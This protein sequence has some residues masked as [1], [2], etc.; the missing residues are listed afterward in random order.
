[1]TARAGKG[2]SSRGRSNVDAIM[3]KIK[4]AIEERK[5]KKSS[6]IDLST[7]ENWLIRSELIDACKAAINQALTSQNF[8]YP[9]GFSGDPDLLDAL[10]NFFND[11]FRP[12]RPVLPDHLMAAPGASTCIDSLLYNICDA[13]DGVLMPGP[14]WNGF[15]FGMRVRSSVTP[16]LVPLPS[17]HS[18]FNSDELLKALQIAME[19]ATCPVKALMITNPHNPLALCYAR[20]VIEDCLRFCREKNLHFISDEVYALSTFKN[21]DIRD[22]VP[23]SSVLS[24]D[25]EKVGADPSRVHMVWSLS[26]DFGQSGFRVGCAVTQANEELAI[27]LALAAMNQVSSLS[28]IFATTLLTSPGLPD[29]VRINS[30]RL[31]LSYEILTGFFKKQ[32]IV[33]IPCNAGLYV[34]AKLAANA[35]T[36]EDEASMAWSLKDAGVLVSPGQAYHGPDGEFGWMRVGF[37]VEVADLKEAIE[38]MERVVELSNEP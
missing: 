27:G 23:F 22:P 29:L 2:L 14:Y 32:H 6:K 26:K 17:F 25:L 4:G 30:E 9:R 1:M 18:N 21:P 34:F 16:V 7:A 3:P 12:F 36:Y 37:A 33:Y 15:D 28:A 8:S 13:G 10:A 38:R 24:L 19:N 35:K 20:S 31:S 11:Y 5:A